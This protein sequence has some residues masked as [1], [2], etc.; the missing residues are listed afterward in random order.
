MAATS[1]QIIDA[2][3]MYYLTPLT[4]V[5]GRAAYVGRPGVA[6]GGGAGGAVNTMR[7]NWSAN[8]FDTLARFNYTVLPAS[9]IAAPVAG[10]VPPAIGVNW[11]DY[12]QDNYTDVVRALG[13]AIAGPAGVAVANPTSAQLKDAVQMAAH[14]A[15]LRLPA[16]GAAG[17]LAAPLQEVMERIFQGDWSLDP[18]TSRAIFNIPKSDEILRRCASVLFAKRAG[19]DVADANAALAASPVELQ[20]AHN[21]VAAVSGNAFQSMPKSDSDMYITLFDV[22]TEDRES[23]A[24]YDERVDRLR[25]ALSRGPAPGANTGILPANI[26]T[27]PQV[28]SISVFTNYPPTLQEALRQ[29][30]KSDPSNPLG[31]AGTLNRIRISM[32]GG[33][34]PNNLRG[35]N[36][37]RAGPLYPRLVMHGGAHPFAVMEG[38]A[39][40]A[41][42]WPVGRVAPNP[43][44]VLDARI[45]ELTTQFNRITG[46]PLGAVGVQIQA[47]SDAL[48]TVM[49]DIQRDL[50]TLSNAN[51]SLAQFQ[52]GLNVD[53]SQS[54]IQELKRITDQTE[55]INKDAARAANKFDKLTQIKDNLEELV[56]KSNAAPRT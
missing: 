27:Q 13:G 16:D 8:Q 4:K 50:E 20:V 15:D 39:V 34:T 14:S 2:I 38:G 17:G 24:R 36:A 42:P 52:S 49:R 26:V 18:K 45:N 5:T 44:A 21:I 30:R 33:A 6:G 51:K 55:K 53:V 32:N 35:G 29:R 56:N 23:F 3:K 47:Y 11:V 10:A 9:A 1:Q 37:S 46:K 7:N 31:V 19:I 40:V 12:T 43:V 22:N 48:N 41:N 25:E 28:N 54:T